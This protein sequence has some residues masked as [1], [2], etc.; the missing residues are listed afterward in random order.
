MN[1][2]K[3]LLIFLAFGIQNITAQEPTGSL[4]FLDGVGNELP[5]YVPKPGSPNNTMWINMTNQVNHMVSQIGSKENQVLIAHS[6][7]GLRALGYAKTMGDANKADKI[8]ALITIGSPVMGSS[9]LRQGVDVIKTRLDA[10]IKTFAEGARLTAQVYGMDANYQNVLDGMKITGFETDSL[11]T[12]LFGKSLAQLMSQENGILDT[13][14]NSQWYKNNVGPQITTVGHWVSVPTGFS[15]LPY[16][17]YYVIDST[18][19]SPK[20]PS[21]IPIGYVVGEKKSLQHVVWDNMKLSAIYA[22]QKL[23][24]W[25]KLKVAY[26]PGLAS[27]ALMNAAYRWRADESQKRDMDYWAEFWDNANIFDGD[28]YRGHYMVMAQQSSRNAAAC[29]AAQ[30]IADNYQAYYDNILG[31]TTH[32]GLIVSDDQFANFTGTKNLGG[33]AFDNQNPDGSIFKTQTNHITEKYNRTIWGSNSLLDEPLNYSMDK[34]SI[35]P[36][37]KIDEWLKAGTTVTKR[38]ND[39]NAAW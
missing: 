16:Y 20:I 18:T 23:T 39:G 31:S 27:L 9:T 32:D 37:G 28:S 34:R 35:G 22:N 3:L 8:K 29:G 21:N 4:V 10:I 1:K 17:Y 24:Y 38:K 11:T 13:S 33:R 26:A 14:P 36:S 6:Q 19:T 30:D 2:F 7:G 25:D 5:G 15:W 12:S